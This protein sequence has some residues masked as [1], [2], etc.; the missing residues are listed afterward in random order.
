MAA[1][2]NWFFTLHLQEDE[3]PSEDAVPFEQHENIAFMKCQVEICPET[4]RLHWQGMLELARK[5]KLAWLK[6]NVCGI[7]HWEATRNI[8]AARGYV[9]KD[10]TAHDP[11]I[12]V[13]WGD[14]DEIIKPSDRAVYAA[15]QGWSDE[16]IASEDPKVLLQFARGIDRIRSALI[17]PRSWKTNVFI[18]WGPTGTGKTERAFKLAGKGAYVKNE[19][20]RFWGG[21]CGHK[22]VIID[23]FDKAPLSLNV[24]LRIADRY[25]CKVDIY[26]GQ[27]EFVATNIWITSSVH[28]KEWY[29]GDK[30]AWPQIERRCEVFY[31]LDEDL[32]PEAYVPPPPESE[33]GS[34]S[35]TP[36]ES[37]RQDNVKNVDS[38]W[39][40]EFLEELTSS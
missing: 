26:G 39:L 23:E 37:D 14:E 4:G 33:E 11:P 22:H 17:Q 18:I 30:S 24:L 6:R 36:P 20:P 40:D 35:R 21:Y 7:T 32:I 34:S 1:R 27:T 13:M 5:Q 31:S 3:E 8:V 15:K 12:R 28:P 9:W 38:D 19:N 16:K 2:K 29:R 10:E 25:P